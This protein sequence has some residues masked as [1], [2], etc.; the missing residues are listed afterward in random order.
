MTALRRN[1]TA[2]RVTQ[3][4]RSLSLEAAG[5]GIWRAVADPDYEANSG[6]FGGW[7]AALLLSALRADPAAAGSP[8]SLT[9]NYVRRVH[10]GSALTLKVRPL[11]GSRSLTHVRCDLH[12]GDGPEILA[13]ATAVFAARRSSDGFTGPAMP[14]APDPDDL[15]S[16]APPTKFGERTQNR[17]FHGL[18]LFDRPDL[19]SLAWVREMSGRPIDEILLTYLADVAVPRVYNISPG[20]RTSS[21][22]SFS[23]YFIAPPEELATVGDE[24][25]LAELTGSR[26]AD[27]VAPSLMRLWSRDGR[28]LATSEQLSW[29]R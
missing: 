18:P 10:P 19:L 27:S 26:I 21:T 4:D 11:G 23:V 24:W 20:P 3:L 13:T 15:P 12:D 28:L 1:A 25:L 5:A 7:T 16:F 9:V 29:F 6:M 8:V 17:I 22:V 2:A 14:A